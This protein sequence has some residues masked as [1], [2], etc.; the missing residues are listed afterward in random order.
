MKR[1][2]LLIAVICSLFSQKGNAVELQEA[3]S[4]KAAVVYDAD[5]GRIIWEKNAS[6]QMLIASTTKIMTALVAVEQCDLNEEVVISKEMTAVEGSS[7][8]LRAGDL[9]TVEEL[10]YGLMLAS[11]NDAATA[12]AIHVS[13][14]VSDFA[15]LM[16]QKAAKLELV[17]TSFENPHGLDGEK[18]YSTAEDMAKLASYAMKN[19][20]FSKIVGTRNISIHDQVYVNHNKLLW[21]YDGII[22]V[23]TGYTKAAGRTLV[24]CCERNGRRL[25]CVTLSA[26]DDW[27]DHKKLY[28]WAFAAYKERVVLEKIE[29]FYI[30]LMNGTDATICVMPQRDVIAFLKE[31]ESV[32]YVVELPRY[33]FGSVEQGNPAGQI[34]VYCNELPICKVPLIYTETIK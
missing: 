14:D 20:V 10:L 19:P 29:R 8:Y 7:M 23:K 25:V 27:N 4:A 5:A 1:T 21:Q 16:N 33:V 34:V 13:G 15:F 32:E 11:G 3:V 31:D 18:H 28:D 9:Y 24:S 2:V 26:S 12:L 30:P 6:Q 22:G 17:H